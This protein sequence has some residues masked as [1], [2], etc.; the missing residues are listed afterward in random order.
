MLSVAMKR[1]PNVG[2]FKADICNLPAELSGQY[3]VLISCWT[4]RNFPDLAQALR[5]MLR[6]LKPG[7]QL[8]LIDCFRPEVA[9]VNAVNSWWMSSVIPFLFAV[10]GSDGTPYAYLDRTI[11]AAVPPAEVSAMLVRAR[12]TGSASPLLIL[13]SRD[14]CFAP[15]ALSPLPLPPPSA[16]HPPPHLLLLSG[17]WARA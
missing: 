12:S 1:H 14:A 2:F 11:Q 9:L 4:L 5:E 17:C 13:R 15:S 6:V 3:D 16:M 10:G 7:G 8:M